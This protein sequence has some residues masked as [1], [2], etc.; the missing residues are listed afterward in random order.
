MPVSWRITEGFVRLESSGPVGFAEWK[1]ALDAALASPDYR[2]GMGILHDQRQLP[3]APSTEEGKSRA[4]YVVARGIRRWA[5]LVATDVQYG[6]A[7]L[8]DA[9]SAGTATE[10]QAFRDPAEAEAWA[11]GGSE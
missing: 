4:A 11:R 6:M 7:R 8:G 2:P 3:D 9:H 5:V 10:I 1:A